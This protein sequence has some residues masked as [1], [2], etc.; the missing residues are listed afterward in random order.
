MDT[1]ERRLHSGLQGV[2]GP[3]YGAL[4][5]GGVARHRDIA[6]RHGLKRK[7]WLFKSEPDEFSLDH[8]ARSPR[9]T[10][11]WDGVRNYQARNMLRDEIKR[12]DGVL[13]Y[14]SNVAEPSIVGV[15]EVVVEGAPDPTAF[16]P[17]DKHFDPKSDPAQPR[18]YGVEI[19][20]VE[21]FSNPLS[22][23]ALRAVSALAEMY[24]LRRGMRLSIQPVTAAEWK[25]VVRLG[26]KKTK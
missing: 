11:F 5:T 16:D 1:E 20:H 24:V 8:L 17:K 10:E 22:R 25:T 2:V 14:H 26:R 4:E 19:R 23:D 7:Y 21:T 6:W 3:S 13:F 9:K 12:G 18:W 15:A